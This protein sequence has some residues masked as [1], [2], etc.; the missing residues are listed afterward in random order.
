MIKI[1][2]YAD[3]DK[4]GWWTSV[5]TSPLSRP[6]KRHWETEGIARAY[7]QLVH[8]GIKL[9]VDSDIVRGTVDSSTDKVREGAIVHNDPNEE[10]NTNMTTNYSAIAALLSDDVVGYGCSFT[11]L[12]K[13]GKATS[14]VY[15]FKGLRDSY[16]A[17]DCVVVP[18]AS[19]YAVAY[20]VEANL[21]LDFDSTLVYKWVIDKVDF[22]AYDDIIEQE[23]SAIDKIKSAKKRKG[24]EEIKEALLADVADD[25]PV[26]TF[27]SSEEK[28]ND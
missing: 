17:E 1:G 2:I 16:E 13:T 12:T 6:F 26:L 18:G 8:S 20:I 24:R 23:E 15:V 11:A 9:D 10:R 5:T 7:E 25:I 28:I 19:D 3:N 21:E 4:G 22:T 27:T 14:K